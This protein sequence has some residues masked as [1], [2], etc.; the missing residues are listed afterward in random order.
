MALLLYLSRNDFDEYF[1]VLYLVNFI[2]ANT[3]CTNVYC[4]C[5]QMWKTTGEA[6]ETP[7]IHVMP[8]QLA[9]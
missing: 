2:P 3:I 9:E 7:V 8:F 4:V 5:T 1:A 6:S